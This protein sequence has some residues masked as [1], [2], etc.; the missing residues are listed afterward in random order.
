MIVTF[1]AG[2]LQAR[3]QIVFIAALAVSTAVI[4][5]LESLDTD[6]R[7]RNQVEE[8]LVRE[9]GNIPPA[10]LRERAAAALRQAE[11]AYAR[12]PNTSENRAGVLTALAGAVLLGSMERGQAA[13]RLDEVL[14]AVEADPAPTAPVLAAALSATAAAFPALQE[15]IGRL[16][17]P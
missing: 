17:M 15:R 9:R 11:E 4:I 7:I 3:G 5:R 16:P 12:S 8:S 13:A 10:V 6:S 2:L 1:R 14:R